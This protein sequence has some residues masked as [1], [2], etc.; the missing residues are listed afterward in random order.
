MNDRTGESGRLVVG[1][2]RFRPAL[3]QPG[4]DQ[5][6]GTHVNTARCV[7]TSISRRVREIVE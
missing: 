4:R 2:D 7:S 5:A 6:L 3:G 1:D